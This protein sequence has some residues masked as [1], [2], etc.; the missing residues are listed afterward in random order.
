M[1]LKRRYLNLLLGIEIKLK[2]NLFDLGNYVELYK[3]QFIYKLDLKLLVEY[4]IIFI[5]NV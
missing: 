5:V 4:I 2:L 1:F 3:Y